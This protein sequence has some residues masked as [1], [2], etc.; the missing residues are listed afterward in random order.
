[1]RHE[2]KRSI[3]WEPPGCVCCS[4]VSSLQG[5]LMARLTSSPLNVSYAHLRMQP[6]AFASSPLS[7]RPLSAS[8]ARQRRQPVLGAVRASLRDVAGA[9]QR[10]RALLA[11]RAVLCGRGL[12]GFVWGFGVSWGAAV[13][14]G[15]SLLSSHNPPRVSQGCQD[16]SGTGGT[17]RGALLPLEAAGECPRAR[18]ASL[19]QDSAHSRGGMCFPTHP[20]VLVSLGRHPRECCHPTPQGA[21]VLI[22][23]VCGVLL[24]MCR[25]L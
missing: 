11:L 9:G 17:D 18:R 2:W 21:T 23:G 12:V 24:G 1:M 6:A 14:L 15:G 25:G 3:P 8:V 20:C 16:S 4:R 5:L 13:G 7:S 10:P 19:C 22:P